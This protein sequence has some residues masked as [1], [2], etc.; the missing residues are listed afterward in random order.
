V[1]VDDDAVGRGRAAGELRVAED[2]VG[3]GAD[4]E[5]EVRLRLEGSDAA[6]RGTLDPVV[7]L[8]TTFAS[9]NRRRESVTSPCQG[10]G[11]FSRS[12]FVAAKSRFRTAIWLLIC[13][14][15]TFCGLAW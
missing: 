6:P 8:R 3:E 10:A 7:F 2:P 11:T 5:V 15:E 12:G 1:G 4:P 13:E 14:S 9:L